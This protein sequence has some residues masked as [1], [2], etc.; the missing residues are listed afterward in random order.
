MKLDLR[1]QL[2]SL[3]DV[4]SEPVLVE[5]PPMSFLMIDGAGDPN[6]S[7]EYRQALEALF[8]LSYTLKFR[9]KKAGGP[10]YG[11]LPLE[12]LWWVDDLTALDFQKKDNWRWTSMIMQPDLIT[13]EMVAEATEE[14]RRKKDPPALPKMR[15]ERFEEG[16]AAQVMHRGPF[17]A[18]QPTVQRLHAF[19]RERG[20]EL[21]GR[22]HEIYLS[23]FNRTAPENLR[24]IVR[25]PVKKAQ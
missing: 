12:G 16:L 24:T 4:P 6:G 17:A 18:E 9:M 10:D 25:H 3:Y 1:K 11:V 7:E 13:A 15:F 22:H 2:R 5:V 14:L 8:G 21:R 23:D 20:Y 19:V